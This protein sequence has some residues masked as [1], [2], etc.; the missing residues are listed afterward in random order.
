MPRISCCGINFDVEQSYLEHRRQIHGEQ[1]SVKHTC[2]GI[3]F[4]TEQWYA[5]HR[6]TLHGE[7]VFGKAPRVYQPSEINYK[8]VRPASASDIIYSTRCKVCRTPIRGISSLPY[9]LRGIVPFTK[10]P[11]LCNRCSKVSFPVVERDVTVLFADVRD[12]TSLS[13]KIPLRQLQKL[14]NM[15]FAEASEL[16][17]RNDAIVDKFIGDAIMGL[18]NAP[19][20]LANHR[21]VALR[22]AINLQ[23]K[24]AELRLPFAI[25]I[26]L[27][28]G[29]ALTGNVGAG[30]VTDYTAMGDTVNVASRLAGLAQKGEILAG[31]SIC[32]DPGIML[33]GGFTCDRVSLQVKGKEQPVE[34]YR[35][36]S[37]GV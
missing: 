24:V 13:E 4:Y 22:T 31:V 7:K 28:S 10:N 6:E 21:E 3:N 1:A 20:P 5:E 11:Q 30:E 15:F 34:A 35:I 17:I 25:G 8:E 27:N 36:R 12:F 9:R 33:P 16:I 37:R 14:L 26:G 2:C 29:I 32:E 23:L 18:F 19:I